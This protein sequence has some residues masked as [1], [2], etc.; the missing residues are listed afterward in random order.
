MYEYKSHRS[1]TI[2]GRTTPAGAISNAHSAAR[3]QS[4]ANGHRR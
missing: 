2:A 3:T 4:A 1:G